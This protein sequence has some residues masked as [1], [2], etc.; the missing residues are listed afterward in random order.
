MRLWQGRIGG[1]VARCAVAQATRLHGLHR[2]LADAVGGSPNETRR[3]DVA[4]HSNVESRF[5]DEKKS[6]FL[7][8]T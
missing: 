2:R 3:Q 4:R 8:M 1:N 7:L 5:V 6:V